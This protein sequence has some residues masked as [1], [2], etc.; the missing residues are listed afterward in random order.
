MFSPRAARTVLP[1]TSAA[2]VIN[3]VQGTY[4]HW[5]GIAQRPGGWT[6]YN[7]ECGPPMFAPLL[8]SLVGGMGLLAAVLRRERAGRAM[9]LPQRHRQRAVTPQHQGR[10]PGF[11]VLDQVDVLGRRHRRCG[12][13]PAG[14]AERTGVLHPGRTGRR[15]SRCWIC[16]SPR[17][18]NPASRCWR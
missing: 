18:V 11:D 17:T 7:M 14:P 4:L 10:Y 3:G 9:N 1:V 6:R 5:R 12:A 2:I 16:C 8:A 15:R 13:G